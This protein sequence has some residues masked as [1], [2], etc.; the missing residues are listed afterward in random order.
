MSQ[1]HL[2]NLLLAPLVSEKTARVAEHGHYVF[3][4]RPEATKLDIKQAVE[5]MF[6]VE[7]DSVQVSNLK[8]KTKIFRGTRGRRQGL[9]KAFVRLK[10]GFNIEFGA[11]P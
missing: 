2:I 4:V 8:G 1:E 6:K 7:V 10:P 11:A 9:R 5:L 3:A